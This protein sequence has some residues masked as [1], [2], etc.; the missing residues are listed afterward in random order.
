MRVSQHLCVAPTSHQVVKQVTVARG[1]GI[2]LVHLTG[3]LNSCDLTLQSMMSLP[4]RG[5]SPEPGEAQQQASG[6]IDAPAARGKPP[7]LSAMQSH[8][9]RVT[10][11]STDSFVCSL[12]GV[13]HV[14]AP[15]P[16]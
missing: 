9:L 3:I 5:T 6:A 1:P 11:V 4:A 15:G 16:V 14:I 2:G 7:P 12:L 13:S 10:D 8:S